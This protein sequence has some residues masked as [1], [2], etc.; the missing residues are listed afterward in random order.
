MAPGTCGALAALITG[1][2]IVKLGGLGLLAAVTLLLTGA[3]VPACSAYVRATR[4][5]D[6]PEIVIDEVAGQ[7]LALLCVPVTP[8]AWMLAFF[9]FR[10]FDIAK[11]GPVGW[12][13]RRFKDGLG[14]MADDVVAGILAGATA[15]L[16]LRSVSY[17]ETG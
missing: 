5:P 10:F 3:A 15:W 7:W 1:A 17:W 12:A 2:L 16:I 6:S 9:L 14:V 13:E 8:A 11:P 4:R